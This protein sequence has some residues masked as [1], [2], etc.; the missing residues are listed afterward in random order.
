[1]REATH[2]QLSWFDRKDRAPGILTNIFSENVTRVKG[3][4]SENLVMMAETFMTLTMSVL[5]SFLLCWQQGV[6][7]VLASPLMIGSAFYESKMEEEKAKSQK[8]RESDDKEITETALSDID[9]SNALFSDTISN[10]RTVITFGHKGIDE[11][12]SKFIALRQN[13]LRTK[14]AR[15]RRQAFFISLSQIGRNVFLGIVFFLGYEFTHKV[16]GVSVEMVLISSFVMFIG[17]W[18][19]GTQLTQISG[20]ILAKQAA[21]SVFSIIDEQSTLDVR[22]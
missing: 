3:M 7:G 21:I 11:I 17:Y 15:V 6:I 1:M 5:I 10:F 20:T 8:Q 22:E 18:G 4:T 13:N 12:N 2:K 9:K 19:V 16:L 14:L